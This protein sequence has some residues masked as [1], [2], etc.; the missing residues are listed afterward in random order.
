VA[1]APGGRTSALRLRNLRLPHPDRGEGV[2]SYAR[3]RRLC[4][5]MYL[6]KNTNG[7][8]VNV[9]GADAASGVRIYRGGQFAGKPDAVAYRRK[10]LCLTAG[11]SRS[12]SRR[13]AYGEFPEISDFPR[14]VG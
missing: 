14:H 11:D 8:L 3:N 2:L 9:H 4:R 1:R 10:F 13:S 7:I 6:V 5:L 12:R